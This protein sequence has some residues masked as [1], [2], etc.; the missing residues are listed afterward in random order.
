MCGLLKVHH[1]ARSVI[2]KACSELTGI[3]NR[4]V[5]AKGEGGLGEGWTG[6]L[7]LADTNY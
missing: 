7:G 3:E 6:S 5:I 4:L 2:K 1:K